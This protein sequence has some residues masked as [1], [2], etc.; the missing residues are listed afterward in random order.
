VDF[1]PS[2]GAGRPDHGARSGKE[3]PREDCPYCGQP[4]VVRSEDHIFPQFMGGARTITCC[5]PCNDR[6]GHRFE[7][8]AAQ[9]FQKLHFYFATQGL[10]LRV[11]QIRW[12]EAFEQ[13]GQPYDAVFEDGEAKFTLSRPIVSIDKGVMNARFGSQGQ[14]KPVLSS[15]RR[16]Y[17]VCPTPDIEITPTVMPKT[18]VLVG[19]ELP[20]LAI[21]M[22]SAV[23]ALLPAFTADELYSSSKK[24]R[25][26]VG[27]VTYDFRSHFPG[28]EFPPALAHLIYVERSET[29]LQGIVRFFG[30]YQYFCQIGPPIAAR[31]SVAFLAVL[32]PVEGAE[33]LRAVPKLKLNKPPKEMTE[34]AAQAA[35]ASWATQL[36]QAARQRGASDSFDVTTRVCTPNEAEP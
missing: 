14:L 29:G 28:K 21:K 8:E 16:K 35:V 25:R 19:P 13:D 22:C 30:T 33:S 24:P 3:E 2:D 34:H 15:L 20:R 6:F 7:A 1:F 11:P 9:W 36:Y 23:G 26:L 32:D 18:E 4:M 5:K 27:H 31:P 17:G 10:P 12:K